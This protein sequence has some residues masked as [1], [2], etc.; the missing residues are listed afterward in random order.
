MA[1]FAAGDFAGLVLFGEADLAFGL[2]GAGFFAAVAGFLGA[3]AGLALAV[4]CA[5]ADGTLECVTANL[6]ADESTSFVLRFSAG[7][8]GTAAVEATVEAVENDPDAAN[9]VIS[10]SVT[11]NAAPTPPPAG[12]GGGGGGG[13]GCV[14]NPASPADPTLPLILFT[15]L[16]ALGVRHR[17]NV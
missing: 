15:L 6:A 2:A 9:N 14:H 4:D 8:T 12:G 3:A 7:T 17:M 10:V 16:M 11:V 13:G 1:G 5:L